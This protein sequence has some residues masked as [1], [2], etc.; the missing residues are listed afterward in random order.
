GMDL[1]RIENLHPV[2]IPKSEYGKFYSKD[3]YIVLQTGASTSGT[4]HYDIF[5]W[6]GKDTS[7]DE[8]GTAGKK[9]VELD[10]ALGGRTVQYRE[11][12]GYETDKFLSLFKPCFIPLEGSM[13]SGDK[14]V[15][16]EKIEPSLYMCKGRHVVRV[17]QV[18]FARSSLNH[19]DVFVLDTN[20]KI[21]QF[22]GATSNI[23]ERAKA[24]DVVWYIQHKY[25]EGKCEVAVIEDGKLVAEADSGEFWVL[26]GG[27]APIGKKSN[28]ED[29]L[30]LEL[31]PGKLYIVMDG[32]LKA[33]EGPLSK[34]V[35]ESNKCYVL[36][37]GS[38]IHVWVGRVTQLED[39][40]VASLA[41]EEFISSQKRGTCV[42]LVRIIQG[43]ETINFKA[44]F[45]SWPLGNGASGSEDGKGKVAS[46]LKK[47]GVDVK[48]VLKATPG[49]DEIPPLLEGGGKLEVWS[50]NNNVKTPVPKEEVGKFYSEGCYVILYTYH[51]ED[52]REDYFLCSWLGKQ[53][54]EEDKTSTVRI[55]NSMA[56][57]LKG[58]PVQGLIAQGK[59]P[60]QFIALFPNLAILNGQM[61]VGSKKE[62]VDNCSMDET[63]NGDCVMLLQLCGT[64]AHNS[65]A[66]QVDPVAASLDSACCFLL[67]SGTSLF[68][69]H[70]NSTTNEQQKSAA[71]FAEFLKPGTSS[72][73]VKEGTEPVA[74]WNALGGRQSY[75]S[76][77]GPQETT[78]DP[79]L[80]ASEFDNGTL[81][82]IEIFNFSQDDLLTE[83][84]M[85]LDTHGEVFIWIGQ[86]VDA[87]L[88]HQGFEIGK[89]YIERASLFEGLS[90][91]TP[92]YKVTEGN[93]PSF[94][95]RYF[96]WDAAKAMVQGNSFEKKL[97]VLQGKP[98][99]TVEKIQN[100]IS[101]ITAGS[102]G[103]PKKISDNLNGLRQGVATQRSAALAALS[104]AFTSTNRDKDLN[105]V[106]R[107]SFKLRRSASTGASASTL[108]V[109]PESNSPANPPAKVAD[110]KVSITVSAKIETNITEDSEIKL[111]VHE[112]SAPE[113][114]TKL[115][116]S[117]SNGNGQE[118]VKDDE[119]KPKEDGFPSTYSYERLKSKSTNPATGINP[120]KRE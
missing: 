100:R 111:T 15:D 71:R 39:R 85:V 66:I 18:P 74:F 54:T 75:V 58:R 32:Q 20:T 70:G 28:N 10:A 24:L 104:A 13:L 97:Q 99:Q 17:K 109:E 86:H 87:K 3:S 62:N 106:T 48:G 107:A 19:D 14:T 68:T 72:K 36:D 117:I 44:N 7:Q 25:H 114:G 6:I 112:G 64:E 23:Q 94:F 12:D 118:M 83:D 67:Q 80:Y 78:G 119:I 84:I 88:K 90:Q 30:P 9:A 96:A 98:A 31:S 89:K 4:R 60:A 29:D 16:T 79:H 56:I 115:E 105:K 63:S 92:L 57:S 102:N 47:Q 43:Y 53:S 110:E 116:E 108:S 51:K 40:K 22:N 120:R 5:F 61:N 21:Y 55:T 95:T 11:L 41:A 91:D 33:I 77:K 59:E 2:V 76:Q 82:L 49:T 52:R 45:E 27:F 81:K 73:A 65:K 35:L 103:S 101:G 50:V 46:L 113:N 42:H 26:F 69:W 1:W 38:E 37:C 34:S 93:E 8:A